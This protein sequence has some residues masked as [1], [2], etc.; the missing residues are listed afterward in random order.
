MREQNAVPD[1]DL[2]SRRVTHIGLQADRLTPGHSE[3]LEELR[4]SCP[5]CASPARCAADLALAMPE[6]SLEDWD[7]YCPNAPRLRILAALTMFEGEGL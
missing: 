6:G 1:P 3:I 4:R 7:D 2:F 5:A